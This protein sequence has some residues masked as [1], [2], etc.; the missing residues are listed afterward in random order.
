MDVNGEMWLRNPRHLYVVE[1]SQEPSVQPKRPSKP[2]RMET[3]DRRTCGAHLV[4]VCF[5]RPG[6]NLLSEKGNH[7][8]EVPSG[9]GP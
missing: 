5:C 3:D 7:N 4:L 8:G 9:D 2:V 6:R 1:I